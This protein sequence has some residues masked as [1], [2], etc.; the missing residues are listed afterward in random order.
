MNIDLKFNNKSY[1]FELR[2]D[3]SI[4]YIED[5]ASKLISKDIS[6]FDLIYNDKILSEY[7]NYLLKDIVHTEKTIP[8]VISP[9]I[10]N[11]S[12]KVEKLFP[13]IRSSKFND[14]NSIHNNDN[15][16]LILNENERC[17]SLNNNNKLNKDNLKYILSMDFKKKKKEKEKKYHIRNEI[18]ESVYDNKES[19]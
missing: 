17:L 13:R 7:N 16:N 1:N 10:N 8:I 18:F 6:S 5:M 9:K 15:N 11:K 4:K 3:I 2:K 19:E 12:T 14:K